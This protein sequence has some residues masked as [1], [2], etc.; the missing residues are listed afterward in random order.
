M[1]CPILDVD[2]DGVNDFVIGGQDG[3]PSMEWW[4][5]YETGWTKYPKDDDPLRIEAGGAFHDI[6]G[7]GDLDTVEG[8]DYLGT[9]GY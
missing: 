9:K 4:R 5:R 6:D 7:D 1:S 8:E 2:N 3:S